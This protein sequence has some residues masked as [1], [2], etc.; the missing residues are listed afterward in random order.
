MRHLPA[1][2]MMGIGG[3]FEFIAGFRKRAPLLIPE[4]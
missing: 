3:S 4:G 2:V 1:K